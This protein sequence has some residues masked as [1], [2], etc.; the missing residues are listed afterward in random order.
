MTM[1]EFD[2][3]KKK[4]STYYK[5]LV[6]FNIG[7]SHYI[8]LSIFMYVYYLMLY[9]LFM[10]KIFHRKI[11]KRNKTKNKP[12]LPFPSQLNLSFLIEDELGI[13]ISPSI[14]FHNFLPSKQKNI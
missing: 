4:K 7:I 3:Q 6:T 11:N 2:I 5:I 1:S 10:F 8:I 14:P 9:L 13:I 12:K